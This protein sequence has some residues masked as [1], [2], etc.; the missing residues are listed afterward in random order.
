[1][2]YSHEAKCPKNDNPPPA[3]VKANKVE[4][5]I[6]KLISEPTPAITAYTERINKIKEKQ[7]KFKNLASLAF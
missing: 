1:L 4:K 6:I 5:N 2:K 3:T 7:E